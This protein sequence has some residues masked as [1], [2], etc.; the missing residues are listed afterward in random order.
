MKKKRIILDQQERERERQQAI[1]R[2]QD[3]EQAIKDYADH[4]SRFFGLEIKEGNLTIRVLRSVD[5][6]KEEGD[7]LNHCVYTNEYYLKKDSLIMSAM[8][9]G[10]RTETAEINLK[11]FTIEQCRGQGNMPTNYHDQIIE[12]IKK[13][14]PKIKEIVRKTKKNKT[15][16]TVNNQTAA[17]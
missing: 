4:F 7:E 15:N 17:A 8:V 10:V 3:L 16:L 5:E 9:D 12:L 2:Q 13:N 1:K 6:F 11:K 14:I